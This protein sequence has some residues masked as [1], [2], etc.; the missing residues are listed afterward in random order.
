MTSPWLRR[1][2]GEGGRVP[3]R[4]PP[5]QPRRPGVLPVLAPHDGEPCRLIGARGPLRRV[6]FFAR[7][8]QASGGLWRRLRALPEGGAVPGPRAPKGLVTFNRL[9]RSPA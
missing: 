7:G 1:R 2:G 3:L 6:G 9:I 8:A 4:P 5:G